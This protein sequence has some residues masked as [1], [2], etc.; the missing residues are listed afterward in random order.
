MSTS[1]P[2]PSFGSVRAPRAGWFR[3]AIVS[4]A[5]AGLLG[6]GCSV[7]R[8]EQ[9][10]LSPPYQ[11]SNV[12]G[13]HVPSGGEVRRVAVLPLAPA[14]SGLESGQEALAGVV[15]DELGKGGRFE[16]APVTP[17]QLASWTGR[18]SWNTIEILPRELLRAARDTLG[19]DAL[20]FAEL[21]QFHAYP[22][23]TV[24]WKFKLADTR[25]GQILWAADEVFDARQPSVETGARSYQKGVSA[26][27]GGLADSRF[28]LLCPQSFARYSLQ[29]VFATL[30][31]DSLP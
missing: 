30:P 25:S 4:C 5:V 26:L 11:P 22:P 2:N 16:L 6:P 12:F 23:L 7:P 28:I 29:T 10:A 27:S 17:R 8:S 19:C 31:P 24:G 15:L 3:A 21:T 20:L 9:V 18:S 13:Q 14:N 1:E